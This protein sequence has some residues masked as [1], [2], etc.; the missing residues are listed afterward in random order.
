[1]RAG[2]VVATALLL[3]AC[4]GDTD[5][6]REAS[7]APGP[8]PATST[9]PPATVRGESE[10][11]EDSVYP[12]V[13]DPGVDALRYDLDLRWDRVTTTLT[14]VERLRFRA[15]ADADRVR[16]DL[17][18]ALTVS[19][20]TLDRVPASY[21]QDGKD[22]L[23]SAT[24]AADSRHTLVVRYAGTPEP[25]PAPVQRRDF[26]TTGWT[27][28]SDGGAWTMQEPF[29]AYTW[30]AV[31]D[32][33][34]DKALY[35]FTITT[36]APWVGIANGELRDRHTTGG[37][38]VTRWVLDEPAASYLVT[39][40]VGE[41]EATLDRSD[42]G[43]PI[44]YWTPPDRPRLVE[45]L[46]AA[47]AGLAWLEDRLGPYPFSTLGFLVVDSMSGMETQTMITLGDN[48]YATSPEV[49]VHEM[50]HHW[51][52][53]Q[54]T[55]R[56]WSD[57]WMNE[58]MATY[59]Q[60]VWEDEVGTVPLDSAVRAWAKTDASLREKFGPPADYDPTAFASSN[61]YTVPALMWHELRGRLGEDTFWRLV[62]EWPASHDDGNADYDEITAWWSAES[63]EDLSA[64]FDDWL[65]GETTPEVSALG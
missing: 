14:G 10:P 49:L 64:F 55:P 53:D 47:P 23:V 33:P 12:D 38:T 6:P 27:P 61:V 31:N 39:V 40:A 50:A 63:G 24:V 45:R 16:L 62:R 43:V 36:P 2:A 13:G 1:M 37:R 30:Y 41:F 54:V 32:Q 52:G 5:E 56:D 9:P 29:G 58:G 4:T 44:T 28:T 42:S 60:F 18:D 25:V 19:S 57:V 21:E 8:A 11:V 22:L 51:Y 65:L 15:T 3:T 35:S 17:S 26:D 59:L 46:R 7:P 48:D 20:V 34:S